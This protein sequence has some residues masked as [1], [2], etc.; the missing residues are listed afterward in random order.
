MRRETIWIFLRVLYVGLKPHINAFLKAAVFRYSTKVGLL[1]IHRK[2][3]CNKV[4]RLEPPTLFIL[5]NRL[6]HKYLSLNFGKFIRRPT[7][8]ENLQGAAFGNAFFKTLMNDCFY[9]S[10]DLTFM[11]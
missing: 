4:A 11:R 8:L 7:F 3:L 6:Q 1:K 2:T 9:I 10:E 5:K